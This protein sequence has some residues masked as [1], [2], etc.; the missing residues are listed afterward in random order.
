VRSLRT[1][2]SVA[3][4]LVG[5]YITVEMLHYPIGASFTGIVLGVAMIAL[6]IVRLRAIYGTRRT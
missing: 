6:G 5:G 2:L 1:L 3:M 4:I